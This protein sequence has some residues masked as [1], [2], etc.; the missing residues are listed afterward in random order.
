VAER[1]HSP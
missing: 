1:L